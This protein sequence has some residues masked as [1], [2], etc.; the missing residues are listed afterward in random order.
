MP[1]LTLGLIIN[2]LA[3]LG[4][5][6]GLKGSDGQELRSLTAQMS[7]SERRRSND[8]AARALDSLVAIEGVTLVTWSGPMGG[9]LCAALNFNHSVIGAGSVVTKNVDD[10]SIVVGNP[11][12]HVK[13]RL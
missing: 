3:G 13:Y 8:R 2:P 1:L 9:D 4:G 11:A 5:S 10:N 7:E 6:R 12:K